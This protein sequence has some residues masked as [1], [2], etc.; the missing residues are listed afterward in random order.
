MGKYFDKVR[1]AITRII[2]NNQNLLRTIRPRY[3]FRFAIVDYRDHPPES[4]YVYRKCDFTNHQAAN[5][6]IQNLKSDSGG[7]PPEAV[8]DG[9][10][11]ACELNWRDNV[12][13]LLFHISDSPPHGKIYHKFPE[14][15]WPDGCLCGKTAR[16]VLKKMKEKNISYQVLPCANLLNMMITE[17][18]THI[19]VKILTFDDRI[20]FEDVIARQVQQQLIDTEMTFRRT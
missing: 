6:Y 20:T 3:D 4:D 12:D 8:L 16:D 17:F 1:F 7:D 2:Q 5:T 13:R 15:R 10:D 9:L 14:D 19:D 18:K 11:A